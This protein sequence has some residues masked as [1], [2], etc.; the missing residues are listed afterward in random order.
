MTE[1][2]ATEGLWGSSFLWVI[3]GSPRLRKCGGSD[4]R[5]SWRFDLG[6]LCPGTLSVDIPFLTLELYD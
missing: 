2:D 5:S 3:V 4:D 1:S 6:S